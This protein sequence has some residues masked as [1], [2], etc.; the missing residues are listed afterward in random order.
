MNLI[1]LRRQRLRNALTDRRG[2]SLV[3]VMVVIAIILTLMSVLMFGVFQVFGQSQVDT[4]RL[5]MDK[6]SQRVQIYKLRN[7]K[8]PSGSDGLGA[9]FA[10][11]EVPRDAWD[12]E[13][14]YVSPGPNGKDFD[15]ISLGADGRE[16]GSGNDAD[17]RWSDN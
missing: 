7:K 13:F 2:M 10:G 6:I 4:T 8:V 1:A 9:V 11:E 5:M 17:I 14:R 15:L 16:G 3:E 12:N